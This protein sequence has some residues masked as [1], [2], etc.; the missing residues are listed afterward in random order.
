MSQLVSVSKVL[1]DQRE[2]FSVQNKWGLIFE[3]ECFFA[4]QQLQK[5]KFVMDVAA[6]NTE[7]L[8]NA[9]LNV[10]A[11][12]ISLNPAN[13][14]A[15][16]VPRNGVICL[17]ISYRGLVKLATDAGGIE[18]AKAILVYEGD[19]FVW[20][21]PAQEPTHKADV[22]NPARM[23]AKDPLKNCKGGYC[24]AK[25]VSGGH[26]VDVMSIGEIYKVAGVSKAKDG[27]WL[28]EFKDKY[29]NLHLGW[30]D[31]MALKTLV[32]RASKSWPQSNGRDRLDRA[33]EVLNQHEGMTIEQPADEAMIHAFMDLVAANDGIGIIRFMAK[34]NDTQQ[35]ECYNAA[36]K[37]EKTKLKATVQSL[38]STAN[39][40]INEYVR[41][42]AEYI[43]SG[44]SD[45]IAQLL[46]ELNAD[47]R[48]LVDARLTD[49]Q[50]R[51]IKQL[52]VAA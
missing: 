30:P 52:E 28:P 21:G 19:E 37:G 13:A 51:Q 2:R 11:I 5:S 36:P 17:D 32:K 34:L 49:I 9:I 44:D 48:S 15:Y 26:M 12:G 24:I 3:Q 25:L 39:A 46:E 16:L 40:T 43:D 8:K 31:Q 20:N 35:A 27:P 23:D 22:F 29:G 4:K 38:V 6:G 1:L 7:S 42:I 33:I 45:G 18:W 14:H 47:E 41:Q 50:H 10:A